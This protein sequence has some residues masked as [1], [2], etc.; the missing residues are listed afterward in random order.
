[1]PF[2]TREFTAEAPGRNGTAPDPEV[3]P[4]PEPLA[5]AAFYGPAG[6]FVNT[7]APHS[8]ADLPALLLQYLA[9]AGNLFGADASVRVEGDQHPARLFVALVGDSS[10]ARICCAQHMRPYGAPQTMLR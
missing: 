7:I 4:W 1:M 6:E 10:K 5:D 3:A 8:E 2:H 9:A